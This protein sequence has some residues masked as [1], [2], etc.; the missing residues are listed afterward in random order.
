MDIAQID[1]QISL[2]FWE[3][4]LKVYSILLASLQFGPTMNILET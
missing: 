4:F 1:I 2:T 3:L